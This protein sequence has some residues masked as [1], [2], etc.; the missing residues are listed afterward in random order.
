[1]STS[2]EH[3]TET[4]I[5]ELSSKL[6]ISLNPLTFD[7]PFVEYKR[8]QSSQATRWTLSGV[9]AAI[10]AI[11]AYAVVGQSSIAPAWSASPLKVSAVNEA[12]ILSTCAL[13]LPEALQNAQVPS[14]DR[15]KIHLV[16][17]RSNYGDAVIITGGI[18]PQTTRTWTCHFIKPKNSKFQAIDLSEAG[19]SF[20]YVVGKAKQIITTPGDS[21]VTA[22]VAEPVS[23]SVMWPGGNSVDGVKIPPSQILSGSVIY[24]AISVKVKCPNLPLAQAA[25][26]KTGGIF[27]IWIPSTS[28]KCLVT[29]FDKNGKKVN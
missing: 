15:P 4:E 21:I 6:K 11:V 20:S 8:Q 16:D 10:I 3:L 22:S 17:F 7:K 26:S 25:I 18:N 28:P 14:S 2:P 23:A 27:S 9:A 5:R 1:M 12:T 29:Y 24:G 19:F 13:F